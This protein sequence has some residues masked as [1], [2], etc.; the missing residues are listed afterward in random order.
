MIS[1]C[2][3]TYNGAQFIE[4]QVRSVLA[5]ISENDE[6]IIADDGSTDSTVDKLLA[7]KDVRIKIISGVSS[8]GIVKNFERALVEAKGDIIF[9]CDQDD[10]WLAGKVEACVNALETSILVVTNCKVVDAELNTI[11][12]SFFYTRKSGAGILKNIAVNSYLGCCMAFN[13]RLL[14]FALPMP[15]N[16]PMHDMWLGLIAES[17]GEVSFLPEP[18]LLYRRHSNNASPT[19]SKS[20]FSLLKKVSYRMTLS[21]LLLSRLIVNKLK[22]F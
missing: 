19:A 3:A 12:D 7:F 22:R 11:A 20:H 6:L 13:K 9:L 16:L 1:V 5:Q 18:L 21:Y 4:Q 10:V 15:A 14:N 2:L 8:L 17:E